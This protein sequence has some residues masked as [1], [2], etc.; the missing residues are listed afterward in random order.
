MKTTKTASLRRTFICLVGTVILAVAPALALAQ[1]ANTQCIDNA[2]N[3]CFGGCSDPL[4]FSQC[5]LGCS[6]AYSQSVSQCAS[7]C[8]TDKNCLNSCYSTL[9]MIATNCYGALNFSGSG[10][11]DAFKVGYA[12]Q[13]NQ[14]DSIINIVNAGTSAVVTGTM[15]SP[16]N[17]PGLGNICLNIYVFNP[18]EELEACCSCRVTPNE[19]ISFSYIGGV[20]G[21]PGLLSNTANP[22]S[23]NFA[24]AVTKLVATTGNVCNNT[25]P[26]PP[27]NGQPGNVTAAQPLTFSNLAAGLTAWTTHAHL[28]NGPANADGTLPVNI[29][30]RKFAEKSL[31]RRGEFP[32]EHLREFRPK[33]QR[34]RD[35]PLSDTRWRFC[36]SLENGSVG[37]GS[38]IAINMVGGEKPRISSKASTV[39]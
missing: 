28:T 3:Q 33:F 8:S 35:L 12:S 39:A 17:D 23:A 34:R 7:S 37:E 22:N 2:I 20:N 9:N 38:S 18:D 16:A 25:R 15:I 13:L 10:V 6:V 24:S 4:T 5:V 14:A 11:E 30:E 21:A 31:R 26:T 29:T 19:L 27:P 1:N 32:G 36:S